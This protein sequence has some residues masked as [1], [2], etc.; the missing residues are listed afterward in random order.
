M[1]QE[2]LKNNFTISKKMSGPDH[3][4]ILNPKELK[5][6]INSLRKSIKIIGSGM[7]MIIQN[8]ST[9]ISS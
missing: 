3:A 6:Y 9:I 1:V 4:A 5:D 2:Y 8:L 7:K